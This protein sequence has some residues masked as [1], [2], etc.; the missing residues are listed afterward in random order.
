MESRYRTRFAALKWREV[1][2]VKVLYGNITDGNDPV[3]NHDLFL[4]PKDQIGAQQSFSLERKPYIEASVGVAN[5]FR[6]LRVDFIKRITYLDHPHVNEF[7][8]R[9]RAKFDF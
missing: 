9:A 1:A 4:L 7:G 8:I 3:L 2:T 6:L 5:I